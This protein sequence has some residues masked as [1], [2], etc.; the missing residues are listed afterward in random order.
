MT[1]RQA[2][3]ALTPAPRLPTGRA[4]E[5]PGAD[6]ERAA[7]LWADGVTVTEIGRALGRTRN[8]IIGKANRNRGLFPVRRGS[9]VRA[10]GPSPS[11]PAPAAPEA[12]IE[13]QAPV[14]V[15]ASVAAAAAHR[16]AM[17]LVVEISKLAE[18]DEA[19]SAE[20]VRGAAAFAA[21]PGTR[22]V[23]LMA[24][25]G[26]QWPVDGPVDVAGHAGPQLFCDAPVSRARKES[27]RPC[28]CDR[29]VAAEAA[30]RG[31][32]GRAA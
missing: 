7:R 32:T 3:V 24:R 5:W 23:P 15:K 28:W 27:G 8:S 19:V 6:L 9:G 12:T 26:C 18:G 17:E 10:A 21:L 22:P 29:H 14:P 2:Q 11:Q 25:R 1:A 20:A 30:R 4:A 31:L 16:P 13:P